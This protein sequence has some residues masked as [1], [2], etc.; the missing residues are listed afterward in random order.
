VRDVR[1]GCLAVGYDTKANAQAEK[2]LWDLYR[3]KVV[4]S[5]RFIEWDNA[6]G[7]LRDNYTAERGIESAA[8]CLERIKY[9]QV[10]EPLPRLEDLLPDDWVPLTFPR[11]DAAWTL[12][13]F[14]RL[15]ERRRR[16]QQY[17][18]QVRVKELQT[19]TSLLEQLQA[20]EKDRKPKSGRRLAASADPNVGAH[21]SD[22]SGLDVAAV[23]DTPE[24]LEQ[25]FEDKHEY[26][27][28][29]AFASIL[30]QGRNALQRLVDDH[31]SG[32]APR[33]GRK[34]TNFAELYD[35]TNEARLEVWRLAEGLQLYMDSAPFRRLFTDREE[36]NEPTPRLVTL[37]AGTVIDVYEANLVVARNTRGVTVLDDDYARILEDTAHLVDQSLAGIDEFI[38]RLVGF[39]AV[40]PELARNAVGRDEYHQLVIDINMDYNY[41]LLKRITRQLRICQQPW[42]RWLWPW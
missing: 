35:V 8:A 30:V 41:A 42:R 12:G 16:A 18:E 3:R 28:W 7:M 29:A 17:R 25:L 21:T 6:S 33:S 20:A 23:A 31:R 14:R 22:D 15:F 40:L 19:A 24:Q 26:W 32:Y 34:A 27:E 11:N 5:G 1:G 38:T 39:V 36:Y 2:V 4:G 13:E 9:L 37:A 10:P